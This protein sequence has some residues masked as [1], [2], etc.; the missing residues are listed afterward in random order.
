M[1]LWLQVIGVLMQGGEPVPGARLWWSGT[2]I[3][4]VSDSTGRFALQ[5]PSKF[6]VWLRCNMTPES[7]RVDSLPSSP[8]Y[9]E[10]AFATEVAT[11]T[12]TARQEGIQPLQPQATL[13]WGRSTLT[14][15]PCCNLSEVFEGTALVDAILSDG[16]LGL[17]QLRLLGFEPAHVTVFYEN[18][19]LGIG[20]YRPWVVQFIPALWIQSISI[21]K[22]VGSVLNG[23]DGVAGQVQ[24]QYQSPDP[25]E[26]PRAIEAFVR[27]T[28][29]AFLA[30][31]ADWINPRGTRFLLLGNLGWTP[32]QSYAL[33]DHN[34]DGFLDIPLFRHGHALLR[35]QRRDTAGD[36][37]E[38]DVEGLY[39]YRWAGQVSFR[40][41][42]DIAALRAWGSYQNLGLLQ[43]SMRRGWVFSKG[44][45]LS[46]LSQ[47]RYFSSQLQA[48]FN[49]YEARQPLGWFQM[50]YRQPLG[51]TRWI[52]Q[53]GP[54]LRWA[55]YAES[56]STWHAYDTSWK[57][58]EAIL[59]GIAEILLAPTP[60][61]SAVLGIRADWHSFWG[62]QT[63]PR[64][65]FHWQ[66]AAQGALRLSAGRS[67]RVPDPLPEAMP[68]LM[69]MRMWN[70]SFSTW[71][72]V[73]SAWSYGFF[74]H[75]FYEIGSGLLKFSLDGVRAH[76]S[77]PLVWNIEKSWRI[78]VFSGK[79]PALYQSL[80]GEIQ[81]E[82]ADHLRF[83]IGYKLQEVWWYLE[84][85]YVFRPLFPRHRIVGWL[86]WLTLSRRWQADAIL[87]WYG[88]Q[89]LPST[90]EKEEPYRLPTRTPPYAIFTL[91]LTH[92][93]DQWE[94]QVAA[95]NIGGFRQA[96]PI[97]GADRPF[98]PQF[99]ASLI[100]GPIMGRMANVTLRYSW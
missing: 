23:H 43:I 11:Q 80:Y 83:S 55:Y 93:I 3:G 61:F 41:P 34:G 6:P 76:I 29:E 57:R 94:I 20:L 48:G 97:L 63:A 13:V 77:N 46:I 16:A 33:Q 52:L 60:R 49:R 36:L 9:W 96:R 4:T 40:N 30:G 17:R 85:K 1:A 28:G 54:T 58:P 22:G 95:E 79:K 72:A 31:R 37:F 19:P 70:L 27:T 26:Q 35:R 2:S 53:G 44:R 56:L 12:I 67:W 38:T 73:E 15:A 45:G 14:A 90:A 99:D 68:F 81:Y 5:A 74:W 84:Q 75:H 64:F 21:A 18:K 88:S 78:E 82:I 87:S 59:G 71:P 92:R 69:S 8:L 98:S 65:H 66:Y 100:W 62:W 42:S 10:I 39:D 51:D 24:L 89:R 47:G 32:F 91:Q 86:T 25:P 50:V 7:L